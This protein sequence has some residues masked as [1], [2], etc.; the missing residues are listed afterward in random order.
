MKKL[1]AIIGNPIL[2]AVQGF[3]AGAI[4]IW[5]SPAPAEAAQLPTPAVVAE[6]QAAR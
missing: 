1:K 2:L 4:F 6:A 5:V 3:A